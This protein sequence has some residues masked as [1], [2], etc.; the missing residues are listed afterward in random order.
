M[1]RKALR[2]SIL[3]Y[4]IIYE[5]EVHVNSSKAFQNIINPGVP[6]ISDDVHHGSR[7]QN[8]VQG[9]LLPSPVGRLVLKGSESKLLKVIKDLSCYA[10][11]HLDHSE[12]IKI[13]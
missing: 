3:P 9:V 6:L 2:L 11:L 1:Y 5:A 12:A 10:D 13:R 8:T 4:Q 7:R